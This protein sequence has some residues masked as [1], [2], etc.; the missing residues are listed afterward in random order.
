ME[1]DIER[2][3][4]AVFLIG[5][6]CDEDERNAYWRSRTPGERLCYTEFLRRMKYGEAAHRPMVKVLEVVSM[7][8][9]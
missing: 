8:D 5:M 9:Y 2:L 4:K 3:E 6:L 7:S 1:G